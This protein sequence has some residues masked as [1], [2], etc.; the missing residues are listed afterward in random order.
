MGDLGDTVRQ[1]NDACSVGSID[2]VMAFFAPDAVI[3]DLN[4]PPV[5]GRE[6]IGIFWGRIR[7]KWGGAVWTTDSV[8]GSPND[9]CVAAEWT[10]RGTANGAPFAFRGVDVFH[11]DDAGLL[12]EVRQYWRFDAEQMDSGLVGFP[13]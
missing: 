1:Y 11:A 4:H 13:Y 10:M 8:I 3:Y 7:Q 6:A 12:T 5:R 9:I 2:E